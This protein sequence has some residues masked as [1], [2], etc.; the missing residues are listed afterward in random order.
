M[1][2]VIQLYGDCEPWW[3]LEGWESDI[4]ASKEF[5]SYQAAFTYFKERKVQL[6]QKLPQQKAHSDTMLAFWDPADQI[7]CEECVEHLQQFHSLLL[8]EKGH[9]PPSG[10]AT[11]HHTRPCSMKA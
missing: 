10:Q 7:W 11:A 9:L 1:Y 8:L 4:V 2:R 6:A 5:T 3:F